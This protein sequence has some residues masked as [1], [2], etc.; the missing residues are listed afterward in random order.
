MNMKNSG[1]LII[2]ILSTIC[3]TTFE[4]LCACGIGEFFHT[5]NLTLFVGRLWWR[6]RLLRY[7]FFLEYSS[8]R[9]KHYVCLL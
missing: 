1:E 8:N 2:Q 9:K 5:Q 7:V 6:S 3:T 4:I